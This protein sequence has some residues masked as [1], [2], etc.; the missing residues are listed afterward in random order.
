MSVLI[1]NSHVVVW[2]CH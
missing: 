1:I 2:N